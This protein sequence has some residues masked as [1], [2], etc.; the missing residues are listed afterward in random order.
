LENEFNS[1]FWGVLVDPASQVTAPDTTDHLRVIAIGDSITNGGNGFPDLT[2]IDWPSLAAKTLGWNDVWN[3][4][5]GGTGYIA[6][7]TG[8]AF[9]NFGQRLQDVCSNSPDLVIVFGG[10]NDGNSSSAQIQAAALAYFQ[11]VRACLPATPLIVLGAWP[12]ATGPSAGRIAIENA[13][14][15]AVNQSNDPATYFVPIATDP[16]GSWITGTGNVS[17]PAGDGNA[18]LYISPDSVH[19]TNAG[20]AYLATHIAAAMSKVIQQIP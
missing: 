9:P 19:P 12:G 4:A 1:L 3:S 11:A 15:A 20:I 2:A 8:N 6:Q 7:G 18:D 16:N 14:Q 5:I 13:I 17:V 10:I